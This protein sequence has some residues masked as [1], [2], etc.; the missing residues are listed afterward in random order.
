MSWADG[1]L[2]TDRLEFHPGSTLDL[3]LPCLARTVVPGVEVTTLS[4]SNK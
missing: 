2:G 1:V 4:R 3:K